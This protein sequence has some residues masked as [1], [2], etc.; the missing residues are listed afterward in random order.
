V[1][2]AGEVVGN[3]IVLPFAVDEGEVVLLEG[4]NPTKEA[5]WRVVFVYQAHEWL[6]VR[7]HED[8]RPMQVWVQTMKSPDD[9]KKL[10]L[11]GGIIVLRF[12]DKST[13]KGYRLPVI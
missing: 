12:G 5:T 4:M 9:G 8:S 3:G 13:N 2:R 1:F 10:L 6:M 11:G 7:L